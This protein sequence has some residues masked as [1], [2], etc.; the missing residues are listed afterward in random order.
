MHQ[1]DVEVEK[2]KAPRFLR[3]WEHRAEVM[4][5]GQRNRALANRLAEASQPMNTKC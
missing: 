5:R 3:A 2:V 1:E 4:L